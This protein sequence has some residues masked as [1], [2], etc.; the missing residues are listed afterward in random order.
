MKN[1]VPDFENN[2]LRVL[3]GEKPQRATL[4]E[5]LIGKAHYALLS[6]HECQGNTPVDVLRWR[7]EAMTAA[8]Y[9]YVISRSCDLRFRP[10]AREQKATRSS[11]GEALIYDRESFENFRWPD[12]SQMDYSRLEDIKPYLP[13]GMKLMVMGPSGVLENVLDLVE[14]D[15][16]CMMLYDDPELVEA[17]FNEVGSRLVTYYENSVS[18]DTVGFLCSNDDWGFNTQTFLSPADMRK[19][20]FPWHKKIVQIA[21][22][23]GKPCMLH[24]CGCYNEVIDDVIND[25]KFDARH[26]YEDKITPVEQAYEDLNGKIAVLGGIDV[27][28]LVNKTPDDIYARARNMLEVSASKGGYALGSGNSIP[29]YIPH[30]NY[31]AMIRA[32]KEFDQ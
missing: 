7:I 20:V 10:V 8:G 18:A 2:L 21:H 22:D 6:G 4:F 14:Y 31:L 1:R 13:Q 23:H 25:M 28:F 30:E 5:L 12:M 11:N 3:K 16:L 19:Y 17:I 9:D 26:S 15:N 24:S 27:N 32:A 29:D